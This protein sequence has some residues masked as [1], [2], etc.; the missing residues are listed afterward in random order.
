MLNPNVNVQIVFP[1]SFEVT[2]F[3]IEIFAFGLQMLNWISLRTFFQHDEALCILYY[4]GG[5]VA[6]NNIRCKLVFKEKSFSQY[7][8]LWSSCV[9]VHVLL[10]V[11]FLRKS[12][13]SVTTCVL[14]IFFMAFVNMCLQMVRSVKS[15]STFF[16]HVSSLFLPVWTFRCLAKFLF[17]TY[18]HI[19]H[20]SSPHATECC[21][22]SI[23]IWTQTF[24]HTLHKQSQTLSWVDK[25]WAEVALYVPKK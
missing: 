2:R 4:L 14:H 12:F 25:V 17:W 5:W 18:F 10:Q 11:Q 22:G 20:I 13:L 21:A 7:C 8:F 16:L 3:T 24:F 23:W 6:F 19:D 9:N 15:L 1:F